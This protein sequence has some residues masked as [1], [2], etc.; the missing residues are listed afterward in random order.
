VHQPL[1][2]LRGARLLVPKS[3]EEAFDEGAQ[4]I[5]RG[6]KHWIAG[7]TVSMLIMGTCTA[8]GLKIAGIENWLLLGVL[9][10]LGTFIPYLGAICSAVPGVLMGLSQ[11]PHHFFMACLVYLCIHIIEGYI[12]QPLV[13][14]RA[15][16]VRPALLLVGQTV[17]G[18]LLGLPGVVVA[19]PLLVCLQIGIEYFYVERKLGKTAEAGQVA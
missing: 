3:A 13:M 18:V 7:I 4:R 11:S 19:S 15:V 2:Y 1:V 5:A 16:E 8:I 6:L 10:A 14:K 12:V 9:T 17:F